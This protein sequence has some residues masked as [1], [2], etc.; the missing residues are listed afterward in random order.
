VRN[1]A[2]DDLYARA[3]AAIRAS[4]EAQAR[5]GDVLAECEGRAQE[6]P[7]GGIGDSQLRQLNELI[8]NLNKQLESQPVI[9]EAKGIIMARSHCSP[10]EAFDVL[11]RASMRM[12]RK[13]REVAA[14]LVEAAMKP[15]AA[16]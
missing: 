13:L 10:D 11:R 2:G 16:G 1:G 5:L 15:P 12:N 8:E 7:G 9:E 3:E 14:D 6:I 4:K